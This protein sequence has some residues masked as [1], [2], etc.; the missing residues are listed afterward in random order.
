MGAEERRLA[1]IRRDPA[2]L[3]APIVCGGA[4]AGSPALMHANGVYQEWVA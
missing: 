2:P 1:V 4:S 3:H